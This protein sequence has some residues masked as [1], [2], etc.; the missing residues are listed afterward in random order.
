MNRLSHISQF[1]INL[2]AQEERRE[3]AA[4]EKIGIDLTPNMRALRL[5]MTLADYLLSMG[6][7]ASS[8]VNLMLG[9]TDAYCTRPVHIDIDYTQVVISQDRGVHYDPLT[10]IKTISPQPTNYRLM[11]QLETLGFAIRNHQLTLDEA[12]MHL[13]SLLSQ[14]NRYP[15]WITYLSGGGISLGSSLLYTSSPIVLISAFIVGT[16]TT[17]LLARLTRLSLPSFFIQISTALFVTL[18]ATT[19]AYVSSHYHIGWLTG[20]SP[21]IITVNGIVLLVAGMAI[22]SAFQDAIDEY[23]VTA[24]AHLLKVV[25]MTAGI[26]FGVGLG[27]YIAKLLHISFSATS[28]QL[29]MSSPLCQ[30]IGAIILA[31]SFTISNHTRPFS[32]VLVG[33]VGFIGYAVYLAATGVGA[34][35]IPANGLAGLVIG[36]IATFVSRAFHMPSFAVVNAG[37]I[38]L[39]PGLLLYNGLMNLVTQASWSNGSS[40]LLQAVSIAVAIAT[41]ASLGVII[42]RPARHGF[43]S[44]RNALPRRRLHDG[45]ALAS[46][47]STTSLR[48]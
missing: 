15:G 31:A 28:E 5:V 42:G 23:Y 38:P 12:E 37:I 36:F 17:W 10:L 29:S 2:F 9:V 21:T 30:Y 19:L 33:A 32:I 40:L 26:V 46:D 1:I 43:T 39:V 47:S 25:M 4:V 44:I 16:L 24:S 3:Q 41:G 45:T 18:V 22:V 7:P 13:D 20:L 48:G 34:S 35:S 11:Q 8:V 27:L 14:K 6:M